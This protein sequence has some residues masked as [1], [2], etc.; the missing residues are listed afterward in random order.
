MDTKTIEEPVRIFQKALSQKIRVGELIL[1]GSFLNG[2]ATEASDID[3]IVVSDDFKR[4]TED[5]RLD[6]LEA[7][8]E[9]IEPE[10]HPW[11]FTPEE[12]EQASELTSL[13]YARKAGVRFA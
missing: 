11:G 10:I 8:A 6:I 2:K 4:L 12:I 1:F 3:L 9:S 13:G 5:E 7:A